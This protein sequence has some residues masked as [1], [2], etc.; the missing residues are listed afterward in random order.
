MEEAEFQSKSQCCFDWL[1]G[2]KQL[3]KVLLNSI[4]KVD[5]SDADRVG[6]KLNIWQVREGWALA[7]GM[8]RKAWPPFMLEGKAKNVRS[9]GFILQ[10]RFM[11][12]FSVATQQ[13]KAQFKSVLNW[14]VQRCQAQGAT[15]CEADWICV[16]FECCV[17]S[18]GMAHASWM[19]WKTGEK[20][21]VSVISSAECGI[22]WCQ[23]LHTFL[24]ACD[25]RRSHIIWIKCH[26][27]PWSST[28]FMSQFRG[29][30]ICATRIPDSVYMH[31]CVLGHSG[32]FGNALSK[33]WAAAGSQGPWLLL[34]QDSLQNWQE[35]VYTG[36][37][38]FWTCVI[39]LS[40]VLYKHTTYM[41]DTV[42]ENY[43]K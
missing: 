4:H 10:L 37:N 27:V 12:T 3:F 2:L 43:L 31:P 6:G 8:G 26:I 22:S 28:L 30:K 7:E 23:K 5:L 21:S 11:R 9:H 19:K 34:L 14:S 1:D 39:T 38:K 33:V 20:V 36:W 42:R 40:C 18:K 15:K 24:S 17:M 41:L 16:R 32:S 13:D 35:R 25:T 29:D